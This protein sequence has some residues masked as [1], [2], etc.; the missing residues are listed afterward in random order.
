MHAIQVILITFFLFAAWRAVRRGRRG[1]TAVYKVVLWLIVWAA[2]IAIV[3]QPE[4]T[5]VFARALGVTRGVDVPIYVSVTLLFYLVFRSFAR[6]EDIE[7]QLTRIVRAQ[8]L[9]ELDRRLGA[10]GSEPKP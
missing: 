10:P 3:L 1:E 8:A 6:V 9:A 4:V 2:A 5:M 7:R